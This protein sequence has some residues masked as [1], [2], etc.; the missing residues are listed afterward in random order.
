[1]SKKINTLNVFLKDPQK[2]VSVREF[3]RLSKI[4]PGTAS[5]ALKHAAHEGLLKYRKDR[6]NLLF[7]ADEDSITYKHEK[8]FLNIKQI[9]D[10][11]LIE[12]L[13]IELRQPTAIFLF[14]SYA[15][16]ENHKDSDI[17]L[18]V[19]TRTKRDLDV[20]AFEKK[21]DA[22]IQLFVFTSEDIV[23]LKKRNPHLLNNI[24]NGFKLAGFLEVF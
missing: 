17:D 12:F 7:K 2:E 23:T 11:G 15:K 1:M 14:G 24:I 20:F 9:R 16:A 4:S 13:Q 19:L 8:L 18:F 22:K 10:S 6:T 21:L 5:T 3:A